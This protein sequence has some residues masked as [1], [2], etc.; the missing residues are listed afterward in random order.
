MATP[1]PL[2]VTYN[3]DPATGFLESKQQQGISF[4]APKKIAFLNIYRKTH[5]IRVTC[6]TLGL[7]LHTFLDHY[8]IDKAF[9]KAFDE[10][11]LDVGYA[12]Q[13]VSVE[14][15]LTPKGFMDR[16]AGLRRIFP[17]KYAPAGW[18]KDAPQKIV[19]NIDSKLL[20]RATQLERAIDAEIVQETSRLEH[21]SV[22]SQQV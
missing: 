14:V 21:K 16:I 12:L 6:Q 5:K 7:S 22:D 9:A 1:R 15:G 3:I 17:E 18:V 8:K 19:I 2:E 4:D 13:D 20:E 10:A 11:E